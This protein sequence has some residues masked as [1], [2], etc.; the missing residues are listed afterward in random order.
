[1]AKKAVTK[2]EPQKPKRID[3]DY[4][5]PIFV[6]GLTQEEAIEHIKAVIEMHKNGNAPKAH[7]WSDEDLYIRHQLILNW[8]GQGIPNIQVAR[9]L[10][11]LWGVTDSTSR[12]YVSEAMKYL[13]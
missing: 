3:K 13:T 4:I 1:M 10:R 6:N 8:I 2:K 9:K 7:G 5:P 12:L 11:N